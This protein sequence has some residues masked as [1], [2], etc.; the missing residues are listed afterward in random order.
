M[1][2]RKDQQDPRDQPDLP[3]LLEQ[4][5]LP[6]HKDL[7]APWEQPVPPDLSGLRDLR[8]QPERP[9]LS[10]QWDLPGRKVRRE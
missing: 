8:V 7:W 10:V 3:G 9:E 1:S 2:G 6:D 5:G 4:L